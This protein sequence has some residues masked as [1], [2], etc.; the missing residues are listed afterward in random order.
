MVGYKSETSIVV[1]SVSFLHFAVSVADT[2]YV[3]AYSGTFIWRTTSRGP[4]CHTRLLV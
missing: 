2:V 1:W 4:I 3:V